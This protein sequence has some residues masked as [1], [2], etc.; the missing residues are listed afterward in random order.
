MSQ[1]VMAMDM[2]EQPTNSCLELNE[3][4]KPFASDYIARYTGELKKSWYENI[5]DY[6]KYGCC[7]RR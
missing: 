5:R 3:N 4:V 6:S 2:I 7:K 1:P